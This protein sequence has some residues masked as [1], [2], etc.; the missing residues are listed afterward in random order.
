[1]LDFQVKKNLTEVVLRVLFDP[2]LETNN[3]LKGVKTN[4]L[5]LEFFE[6]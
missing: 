4:K 1:V 3:F 6:T 2:G 5:L